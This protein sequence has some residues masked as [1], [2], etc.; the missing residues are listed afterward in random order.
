MPSAK[1]IYLIVL[2]SLTLGG[3]ETQGL[4]YARII[5]NSRVGTPIFVNLGREGELVPLL[6]FYGFK[7]FS[8]N[9]SPFYQSGRFQKIF[10]L[11]RLAI[12]L[13]KY[14]PKHIIAQSYWP[15]LFTGV[16]WRFTGATRF[17]WI[18][19]SVDSEL[20]MTIWE[21]IAKVFRPTYLSNSMASWEFIKK[22]HHLKVQS[23]IIYNALDIPELHPKEKTEC[24]QII[25]VANF[26]PEKDFETLLI[27]FSN[28]LETYPNSILHLVGK[29]PGNDLKM[30]R[31]KA[32]AFDLKLGPKVIFHGPIK[33]I[34]DLL[35]N[36]DIGILSTFSEGLSNSLLEYMAYGLPIVA[37]NIAPNKEA[38]GE[39]N[40]RWL[41][42]PK[43][44]VKLTELLSELNSDESLRKEIGKKNRERAIELFSFNAFQDRFL[45]I[46]R[47]N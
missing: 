26:F 38:L 1:D 13:K 44:V 36:A 30:N 8:V 19:G 9:S 42:I 27:A 29:S 17:Y 37:T 4:F 35:R 16:V 32:L 12:A 2:P 33:D 34:S 43:D 20:G 6:D 11:L 15:N 24:I 10:I 21:K 14:K 7:Y 39:N 41:F 25:M 5:A 46:L 3:C 40:Y 23:P 18:Q 47:Q 45:E 31:M 28:T 22:R